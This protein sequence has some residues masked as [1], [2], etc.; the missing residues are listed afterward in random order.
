[1]TITLGA[2]NSK[3]NCYFFPLSN[4]TLTKPL[5]PTKSTIHNNS[6]EKTKIN[7]TANLIYTSQEPKSKVLINHTTNPITSGGGKNMTKS[8]TVSH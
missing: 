1:M 6:K 4:K 7:K 2:V 3:K 8:I 5:V